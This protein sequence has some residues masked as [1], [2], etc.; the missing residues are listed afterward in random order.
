MYVFVG[1]KKFRNLSQQLLF[2]SDKGVEKRK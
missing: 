1:D 2:G